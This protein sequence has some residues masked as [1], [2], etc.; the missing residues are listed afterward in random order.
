MH[1]TAYRIVVV[2]GRRCPANDL[3]ASHK[4]GVMHIEPGQS[5][6]LRLDESVLVDLN[7]AHGEGRLGALAANHH[8]EVAR[9][10][11]LAQD[12]A[13]ERLHRLLHRSGRLR[14]RF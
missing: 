5:V 12:H 10:V 3:G 6:G 2:Q 9:S 8:A 4:P 1:H 13:G 7:V 11:G 14:I